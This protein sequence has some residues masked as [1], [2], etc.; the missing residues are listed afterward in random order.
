LKCREH[1][2]NFT[3]LY[4]F[5]ILQ[6][7]SLNASKEKTIKSLDQKGIN[8][9]NYNYLA[10]PVQFTQNNWGLFIADIGY[11]RIIICGETE[12]NVNKA[13]LEMIKTFLQTYLDNKKDEKGLFVVTRS[14]I[15]EW[16]VSS[17]GQIC[18]KN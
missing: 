3:R 10:F 2:G 11:Q 5:D 6:F 12:D 16:G 18:E 4:V 14:N 7:E 13:Y 15:S 8:L 1:Q 9:K 17:F